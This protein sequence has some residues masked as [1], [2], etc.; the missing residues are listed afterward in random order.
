MK[1]LA[2]LPG[3]VSSSPAPN[4]T[5]EFPRIR[6]S[7]RGRE[8][9]VALTVK[10]G[11]GLPPRTCRLP[12]GRTRPEWRSIRSVCEGPG[13]GIAGVWC[14]RTGR[15]SSRPSAIRCVPPPSA[16]HRC[17]AES[18]RTPC[19]VSCRAR[20]SGAS[21]ATSRAWRTPSCASGITIVVA[22]AGDDRVEVVDEIGEGVAGWRFPHL[23][24][25]LTPLGYR[26]LLSSCYYCGIV[27]IQARATLR[28]GPPFC[29]LLTLQPAHIRPSDPQTPQGVPL[30]ICRM[31]AIRPGRFHAKYC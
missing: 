15:V 8:P 20:I 17:G 23:K 12:F 6:L 2:P 25:T 14:R 16:R 19:R 13:P 4:R 31:Y 29:S 11:R 30:W 21:T 24:N 5:C 1:R 27:E 18:C 22:P 10:R 3:Q 7:V 9:P 26:F 28:R